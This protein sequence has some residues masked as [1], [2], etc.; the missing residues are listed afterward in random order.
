MNSFEELTLYYPIILQDI[1]DRSKVKCMFVIHRK[2][3]NKSTF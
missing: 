3:L 1:F 2:F